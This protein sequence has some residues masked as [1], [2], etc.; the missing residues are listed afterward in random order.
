M[1]CLV[2]EY[3][4]DVK[5]TKPNGATSLHIAVLVGNLDAVRCMTSELG[6]DV[7]QAR[8]DGYTVLMCAARM[9]NQ[10]LIKHLV[11]NGANI[12][13]VENAGHAVIT[14]L[15]R[16]GGT[17]VSDEKGRGTEGRHVWQCL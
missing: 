6:T 4:A 9:N 16:S 15:K 3:G 12:R 17:N 5:Q 14:Y 13:A 7:N 10:A 2:N 1:R 8:N 11:Y